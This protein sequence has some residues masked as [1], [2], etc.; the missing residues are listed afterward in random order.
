MQNI[1]F[2][3]KDVLNRIRILSLENHGAASLGTGNIGELFLHLL[4]GSLSLTAG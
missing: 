4:E 2:D 3:V 1:L